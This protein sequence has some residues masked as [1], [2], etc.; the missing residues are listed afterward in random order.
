MELIWRSQRITHAGYQRTILRRN[1][2][3]YD[4]DGDELDDDEVDE[5]ADID[6]ARRNPY[7]HIKIEGTE[8]FCIPLTWHFAN[9]ILLELLAPLTSAADLPTHPSLSI[10]YTSKTLSNMTEEACSM[11]HRERKALHAVKNLLTKFR[12]DESFTSCGILHSE[13]D[14]VIFDTE[15]VYKT[16][17]TAKLHIRSADSNRRSLL[18]DKLPGRVL[19]GASR[20]SFDGHGLSDLEAAAN[21]VEIPLL[22]DTQVQQG[23]EDIIKATSA[24]HSVTNPTPGIAES[25]HEEGPVANEEFVGPSDMTASTETLSENPRRKDDD[26]L[27]DAKIAPT[28]PSKLDGEENQPPLVS[29]PS[30]NPLDTE[31]PDH[32]DGVLPSPESLKLDEEGDEGGKEDDVVVDGRSNG[33]VPEDIEMIDDE[34]SG[35]NQPDSQPAPHR[36]TTRAQ[37]QAVSDNS[38]SSRTRSASSASWVPP[39]IHPLY[40][41]PDTALPDRDLGLPSHEAEETRRILIAYVQ[42]QEEVVRGAIKLYDGLLRADRMRKTVFK[43]CKAEGHVGEMSDGEDWYDKE[44]WG[45]EEDLKKGHDDEEEDVATQ[46][47]KT[48]KTRAQ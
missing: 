4:E 9:Q 19:N 24:A 41:I 36:M 7:S 38:A 37:A 45:L 25:R 43:W 44:E 28:E 2:K 15:P 30:P 12:G 1:P 47:K 42:K 46:G 35:G 48:R 27:E 33:A 3:R 6:V 29:L 10:P 14:A 11:L 23:L 22:E 21:N 31:N 20:G 18:A 5:E 26:G 32:K 16:V 34:R 17:M 8:I 40:Q 13:L 39:T